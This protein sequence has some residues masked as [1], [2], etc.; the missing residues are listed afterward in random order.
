MAKEKS[1][2][3]QIVCVNREARH[4][5]FID[6][7]YEAGLVLLGRTASGVRPGRRQ[8]Q[9]R[10]RQFQRQE[11]RQIGGRLLALALQVLERQIGKEVSG[12][13]R[14]RDVSWTFGRERSGP[15]I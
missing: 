4:N 11:G 3:E 8:L 2:G 7:T 9:P 5:Y 13:M 10:L 14:G 12:I 6:E 15:E 1:P